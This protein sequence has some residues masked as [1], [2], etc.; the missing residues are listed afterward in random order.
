MKL[1]QK[2]NRSFATKVRVS[3]TFYV[4]KAAMS[5]L[6]RKVLRYLFVL[7]L[8][9]ALKD[10]R[11]FGGG[12]ARGIL[13]TVFCALPRRS[14]SPAPS[15]SSPVSSAWMLRIVFCCLLFCY[16]PYSTDAFPY[17][18]RLTNAS[19]FLQT[20]YKRVDFTNASGGRSL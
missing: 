1:W 17:D 15:S 10:C 4:I 5:P 11:C 20:L 9:A 14:P 19:N 3:F 8:L 12:K 13:P 6:L 7:R 16:F 2:I 18:R